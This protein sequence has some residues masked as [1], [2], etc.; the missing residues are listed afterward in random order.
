MRARLLLGGV[1]S[2]YHHRGRRNENW[3]AM[4]SFFDAVGL[5]LADLASSLLFIVLLSLTGNAAL[6]VCLAIALGLAQI[7]IQFIRRKPIDIMEWLSLFLVIAA[8]IATLLT[9]DPRFVLF[10]PS[11][12][13]AIVGVVMLKPGWMNRYL[14]AIARSV[15]PDVATYV[16]FV[17]A[18]LMFVS[19]ALNAFLGIEFDLHTWAVVMPAFG[20][21]SKAV[22]MVAGFAAIRL[23]VSRRVRAMP[24][25]ERDALL[26]STGVRA[27]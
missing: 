7:G 4:K 15:A 1:A 17:W 21:V 25:A 20:I 10:K 6:S 12:I 9:D 22:L 3:D 13:Y 19:G 23:T 2:L 14:P 26:I 27:Q 5:L 16:G 18:G 24:E 8:G 11:I